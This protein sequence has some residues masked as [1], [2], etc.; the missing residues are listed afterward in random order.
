[1]TQR[2]RT[3]MIKNLDLVEHFRHIMGFSSAAF[4]PDEATSRLIDECRDD[5][6]MIADSGGNPEEWAS[7]VADAFDGLWRS[8]Y[9]R[10]AVWSEVPEIAT[11]MLR[12]MQEIREHLNHHD[13]RAKRI[14][15]IAQSESEIT[16]ITNADEFLQ[17]GDPIYLEKVTT[18]WDDDVLVKRQV[19]YH[20]ARV[21]SKK[22]LAVLVDGEADPLIIEPND[23]LFCVK[24][25]IETTREI[26]WV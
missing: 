4:G 10:K 1:M 12:E 16:L 18:E 23:R 8:I 17:R 2:K 3:E 14:N 21:S 6:N 22:P 13:Q 20:R 19:A 11:H 15:N 9:A 24:A 5:I 25:E 26:K 7:L